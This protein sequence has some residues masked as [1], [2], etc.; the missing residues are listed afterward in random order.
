[1]PNQSLTGIEMMN[2][3]QLNQL[4]DELTPKNQ[5]QIVAN[6]YRKAGNIILTQIKSNFKDRIKGN[7]ADMLR[8]FT[9]QNLKTKVGC[10]IGVPIK[11]KS[12][13]MRFLE[14]GVQDRIAK[15]KNG[16]NHFTGK[17]E[18]RKFFSDGVDEKKDEAQEAVQKS[19]IESMEKL[20]EK[21]NKM[22]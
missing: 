11:D 4:F 21:Y 8:L 6:G 10:R 9:V 3:K 13:I 12:Y 20:V 1:M 15:N 22:K 19:I 2:D 5:N 18:G 16:V 7:T 17:I 14:Y